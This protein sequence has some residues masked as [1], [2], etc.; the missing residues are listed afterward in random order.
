M[1][2]TISSICDILDYIEAVCLQYAAMILIA[3]QQ[4]QKPVMVDDI[5]KLIARETRGKCILKDGT[6]RNTLD[7]LLKGNVVSSEK[8]PWGQKRFK[9]YYTLTWKGKFIIEALDAF[10]T[11]IR[12]QIENRT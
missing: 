12:K 2:L 7:N 10:C 5:M 3:M 9:T 11:E 1:S 8:K 4:Q 6:I